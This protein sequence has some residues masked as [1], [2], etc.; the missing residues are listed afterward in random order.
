VRNA[1]FSEPYDTRTLTA[2]AGGVEGPPAV[3]AGPVEQALAR[4]RRVPANGQ[5]VVF[6]IGSRANGATRV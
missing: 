1:F 3:G 6:M 5:A 2:S 4:R